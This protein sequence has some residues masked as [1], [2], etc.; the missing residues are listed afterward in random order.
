ME[1]EPF[2]PR[3]ARGALRLSKG[4]RAAWLR[5]KPRT[6]RTSTAPYI[7]AHTQPIDRLV[8]SAY[9]F[10]AK[11]C[12]RATNEDCFAIDEQLGLCVIA[13]GMGGHNAG[14]VAAR[15]AVDTVVEIVARRCASRSASLSGERLGPWPLGYDASLSPGGNLLRTAVLLANL[16]ILESAIATDGCGGMATTIVAARV[17]DGRL[18]VAHVGDSR[19]YLVAKRQLRQVTTDDSW[20]M[21]I[22]ANNPAADPILLQQHPM[23]HALTNVVG[24]GARTEV[25]VAETTLCGGD[26]LL[27][28]TDGV[29]GALDEERLA[30]L[31]LDDVEPRDIARNIVATAGARGSDDDRTAVVARWL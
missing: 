8:L 5:W 19:L 22:L 26:Q 6:P 31:M 25:H 16:Q 14:E 18:S 27:L 20:L 9:G 29:H 30:R 17:A 3:R 12:D 10:T 7:F 23:R 11:G 21:S 28:T 15:L 2:T 13:D 1:R 24:A 4:R